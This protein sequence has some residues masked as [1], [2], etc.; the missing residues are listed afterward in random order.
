VSWKAYCFAT[1]AEHEAW[2]SHAD[3]LSEQQ[4]V[5]RLVDDLRARGLVTGDPA[6][7]SELGLL[8]IDT[9]IKHPAQ[10]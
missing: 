3:D 2:R 9:Y 8:L 1:D 7:D 6:R 4:V 5:D 10:L